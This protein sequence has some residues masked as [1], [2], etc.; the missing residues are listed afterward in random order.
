MRQGCKGATLRALGRRTVECRRVSTDSFGRAVSTCTSGYGDLTRT[1]VE[2]GWAIAYREF[3][4]DY[5]GAEQQAKRNGLG[6]WAGEFELS[7]DYRYSQQPDRRVAEAATT[8][9][10][11]AASVAF[12]GCVIKGNRNRRGE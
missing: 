6:I 5:V 12:S 2:Q 10:R 1:M 3:S 4:T 8:R 11:R 7:S 9:P